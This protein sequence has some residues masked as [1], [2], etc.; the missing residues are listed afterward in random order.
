MNIA[1]IGCGYV[2]LVSGTCL[3]ALGHKV[4]AVDVDASRVKSLR[5]GI[6]PIYEPGLSELIRNEVAAGRLAFDT[7]TAKA[8]RDA[9]TIFIAV[10]TPPAKEGGYDFS[11]LFA[12]AEQI[13]KSANAPKTLV[14]KSTV[15]PGTGSKVA[16]LVDKLA[17][18]RI[19]VVNNPEFLREGT[20]VQD[21]MQPDRIVFGAASPEGI[22]TLREI[23]QPLIDRG[24]D[25][26]AMSRESAELSKFAANAMLATRISFINEISQLAQAIGA[27]IESVR[28]GIGTD[29]RIGP[30][31]LKAG[32]GYGGSCF[33][34]DVQALVHQMK[35]IGIDPLLLSGIEAVNTRQKQLFARRVLDSVKNIPNPRVAV[36]GLAFKSDTDDVREAAAFHVIDTL[37]A[38]GAQVSAYDPQAIDN[39]KKVLKDKITYCESL[40]ACTSGA[41][42]V[43][44]VTDWPEFISQDF[45]KVA[46]LMKGKHLFDGRNCLASGK[47]TDAGLYYHAVGRPEL[48]PGEGKAGTMGVVSAGAPTDRPCD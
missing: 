47:V 27:D 13:A 23:Y 29:K 12:A 26:Y 48:A 14:I 28:V 25:I 38:G 5:E 10:G 18:H 16:A 32:V 1:V 44:L 17:A 19:E 39:A 21:F 6:V 11:Y 22:A 24:Y 36:W 3:A 31:F 33:P 42:A 15:S 45:H 20:A 37:L 7:D 46:R 4:T 2:G 9:A 41:D 35:S 30:S 8:T 43:A 40:D 34:K